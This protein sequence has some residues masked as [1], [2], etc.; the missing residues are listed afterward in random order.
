MISLNY[1]LC[2]FYFLFKI[3]Y[4]KCKNICVFLPCHSPPLSLT[5]TLSLSLLIFFFIRF[6]L[7]SFIVY[8][9][10]FQK[11]NKKLFPKSIVIDSKRILNLWNEIQVFIIRESKERLGKEKERKKKEREK[12]KEFQDKIKNAQIKYLKSWNKLF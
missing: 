8:F 5:H 9:W 4:F 2:D 12:V 1:K 7:P 6:S 3:I 11:T 10:F